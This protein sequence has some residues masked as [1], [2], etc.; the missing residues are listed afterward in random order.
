[1]LINEVGYWPLVI[2]DSG[3]NLL[4]KRLPEISYIRLSHKQIQ[5]HTQ[6]ANAGVGIPFGR[7]LRTV[8]DCTGVKL[9]LVGAVK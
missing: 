2:G 6:L 3:I 7:D 4:V 8:V 1:M 9:Y 5:N